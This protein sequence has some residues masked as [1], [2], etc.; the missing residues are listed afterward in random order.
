MDLK[1][2]EQKSK[3]EQEVLEQMIQQKLADM[4]ATRPQDNSQRY[5]SRR[6][7]PGTNEDE[8]FNPGA[9]QTEPESQW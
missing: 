1:D 7:A 5:G 6:K 2:P 8:P 4:E 9:A 3:V